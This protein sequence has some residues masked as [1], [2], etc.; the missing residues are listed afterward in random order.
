MAMIRA[1][2]NTFQLTA[3]NKEDLVIDVFNHLHSDTLKAADER[4]KAIGVFPLALI[5]PS[6]GDIGTSPFIAKISLRRL[7]VGYGTLLLDAT[8]SFVS[9]GVVFNT[10][11]LQMATSLAYGKSI[12]L[13]QASAIVGG[14]E[15]RLAEMLD[16]S[17]SF[18]VQA[19]NTHANNVSMRLKSSSAKELLDVISGPSKLPEWYLSTN[20][21]IYAIYEMRTES[22]S[23][24]S[25][26]PCIIPGYQIVVTSDDLVFEKPGDNAIKRITW[27]R[28]DESEVSTGFAIDDISVEDMFESIDTSLLEIVDRLNKLVYPDTNIS[29]FSSGALNFI[30]LAMKTIHVVIQDA[31]GFI[32]IDTA[33]TLLADQLP[34]LSYTDRKVLNELITTYNAICQTAQERIDAIHEIGSIDNRAVVISKEGPSQNRFPTCTHSDSVCFCSQ[35]TRFRS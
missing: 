1:A 12:G 29:F 8:Y 6:D 10:S 23:I 21:N 2:K 9:D 13:S 26:H 17:A 11:D 4:I 24:S 5:L 20:P 27:R 30:E 15:Y 19:P 18:A 35:I 7:V 33:F 25:S 3:E 14:N 22:G 16:L 28:N 31:H 34:S 32:S